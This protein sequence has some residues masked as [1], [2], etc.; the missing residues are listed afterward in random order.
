MLSN[1][2]FVP[3]LYEF[4]IIVA[5]EG[6]HKDAIV[7]RI[8]IVD[9]NY[10]IIENVQ[11][12]LES[13]YV[14]SEEQSDFDSFEVA[15]KWLFYENDFFAIA[16]NPK[17]I[18]YPVD[19]IF[20]EGEAY[21]ITLPMNFTLNDSLD[22]VADIT[23]VHPFEGEHHY[24]F[25][26]YIKYKSDKHSYFVEIFMEEAEH[27]EDFFM[28]GGVGY[29]YQFHENVAFMISFGKEITNS[30]QRATVGYS[31]LQFVF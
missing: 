27:Q 8:P 14:H 21:E 2:P 30:E 17:Y 5:V 22:L 6:E 11:L 9:I 23:F 1:D 10:G 13:A 15:I 29:M 25:G 12:T 31:G 19:S 24:E 4:E 16:F 20:N 28:L 26:T 3:D 18:S 7:R